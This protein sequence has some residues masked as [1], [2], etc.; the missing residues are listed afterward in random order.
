MKNK[1]KIIEKITIILILG[2]GV[3]LL[4]KGIYKICFKETL[5][6]NANTDQEWIK[7]HEDFKDP[8]LVKRWTSDFIKVKEAKKWLELGFK[9]S[10]CGLINWMREA[11]RED[12]LRTPELFEQNGYKADI[13]LWREEYKEWK[14]NRG[15]RTE[16]EEE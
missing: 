2:V 13:D 16:D 8:K 7:L 3:F 11:K 10:D 4:G 15:Y 5:T 9:T 6:T 12:N 14:N 1:K